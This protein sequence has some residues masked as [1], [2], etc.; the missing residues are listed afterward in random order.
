MPGPVSAPNGDARLTHNVRVIVCY[1]HGRE[2]VKCGDKCRR[3]ETTERSVLLQSN[4]LVTGKTTE[5]RQ[6]A[7][8]R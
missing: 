3:R 2:L 8:K 4:R 6:S 1:S 7:A 5:R